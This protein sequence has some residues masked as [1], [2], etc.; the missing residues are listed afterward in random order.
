M[1]FEILKPIYFY[2]K[3]FN[4]ITTDEANRISDIELSAVTSE[5]VSDIKYIL[6]R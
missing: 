5:V 2:D 6:K 3:E 1:K 4:G